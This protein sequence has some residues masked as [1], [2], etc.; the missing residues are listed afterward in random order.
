MLFSKKIKLVKNAIFHLF[1]LQ[2]KKK[3][4]GKNKF[5]LHMEKP[6]NVYINLNYL[7]ELM[8][9]KGRPS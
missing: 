8:R 5:D 9:V 7:R 3:K 2:K 6:L 1:D 4:Q